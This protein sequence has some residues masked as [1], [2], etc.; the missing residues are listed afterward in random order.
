VPD[1]ASAEQQIRDACAGLFMAL[2]MGFGLAAVF[3]LLNGKE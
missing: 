1:K 3:G 2:T